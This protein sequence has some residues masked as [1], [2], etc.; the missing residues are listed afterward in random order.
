[1]SAKHCSP[2]T[3]LTH[4]LSARRGLNFHV[5][6]SKR[7]MFGIYTR[8]ASWRSSRCTVHLGVI[9]TQ[10]LVQ[11]APVLL[12]FQYGNYRD[13]AV[14]CPMGEQS[15]EVRASPSY[16]GYLGTCGCAEL[17]S[18][19]LRMSHSEP[20]LVLMTL[21]QCQRRF[22]NS[23]I[24]FPDKARVSISHGRSGSQ[25]LWN[26]FLALSRILPYCHICTWIGK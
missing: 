12:W 10:H 4:W 13:N 23:V 24:T 3:G 25:P 21:C 6:W 16:L 19:C 7:D 11:P 17:R 5:A 15:D 18:Q 8:H 14:G 9:D 26:P 20:R 1:M 22:S 2:K